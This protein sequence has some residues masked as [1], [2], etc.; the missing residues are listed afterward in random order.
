MKWN[1]RNSEDAAGPLEAWSG[2]E[3]A[4]VAD[5]FARGFEFVE[6]LS[7]VL[8]NDGTDGFQ[9]DDDFG[10]DEQVAS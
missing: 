6:E 7:F 4:K 1:E 5:A 3:I 10:M 9:F 8:R 2:T